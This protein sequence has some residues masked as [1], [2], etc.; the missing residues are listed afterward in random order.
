[1]PPARDSRQNIESSEERKRLMEVGEIPAVADPARRAFC[2]S[3]LLEFLRVYFPETTGL[4]EFSDEQ[5]AAI[6]RIQIA[7]TQG[8]GRVLN[9]FPRGFGKTT[10]SENAVLWALMYGHRRFIPI[11]G[12]DEHA[13]KDNIESLKTELMTNDLIQGDFPEVCTPVMHLENKAQRARSQTYDGSPTYITWGQDTVVFPSIKRDGKWSVSSGSIVT[14]RGLTGRIRG[15]AHKRPDGTKQRPDFV[16]I[17]DP[18]TDVSAMSP[19][20]CTKRLNL[21]RK[22]VLRLGGHNEQISAVM[23]ATVIQE[24]D[25]V[26]QLADHQK[27]PEWEGLRIP[28]L[29]R[30][31]DEHEKFWLDEYAELRRNYN[32]EDP[33]DRRRAIADS[34]A[35]Y[36]KHRARAEAG[37]RATWAE[38]YDHANEQSAIQ[39][40]YNIL[41]DDG[42]DVFASECQNQPLRI[43]Q[44]TDFLTAGEMNRDRVGS[45]QKLPPDVC[46]VTFHIDVQ[47]RL[48]YWCAVG[49]TPDFRIYPIYGTYPEQRRPNFEYRTVKRSIQQAHRGM[50]E[51][52]QI[53]TAVQTLV[54][55]LMGRKWERQDGVQ[56]PTDGGLVDGG[57]QTQAVRDGITA[58]THSGRV[59]PL[60][61]RGVK[62]SDNPMLQRA[63][64]RGELRSTDAAIPWIIK[65]DATTR[66]AR[67]VFDDTNALKTFI[68]RRIATDAGRAGSVELPKGDHRRFCEHVCSSEYATEVTGPHG[69]V[70]E[71][72]QLPGSPDNHWFDT[73]CGAVVA[74]S[75]AGKVSFSSAAAPQ[76]TSRKR[77][78]VTYL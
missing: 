23:N 4:T 48:L 77:K 7:M 10:I 5:K 67:N 62:A 29:Q 72:R 53:Q 51:E 6:L 70:H 27:H 49:V 9:L 66:G 59:F 63:K 46:T 41:I 71:W 37:A 43:N 21:I 73:I 34:N 28:M 47:K 22:G 78:A 13:A 69:T 31:A 30:F 60:F 74:A 33:H 20:Q 38:C 18:Q 68:H 19:S 26:D 55:D 3:D 75:I 64:S 52:R 36:R 40:A 11:I 14:A 39:H 17:D 56:L 54:S 57:Y 24:D 65:R 12:A 32:P 42:E 45:W 15:M 2:R 58:S 61:G 50:S 44:G 76:Q 25:A 1:M 16:V 35:Y 8:G